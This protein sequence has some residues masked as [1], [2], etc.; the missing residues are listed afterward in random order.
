MDNIPSAVVIERG[1]RSRGRKIAHGSAVMEMSS[2]A[3]SRLELTLPRRAIFPFSAYPAGP[4]RGLTRCT[5]A[6]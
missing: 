4:R 2:R 3:A 6:K 1:S 5:V